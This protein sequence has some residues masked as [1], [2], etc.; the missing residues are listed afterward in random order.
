MESGLG[1]FSWTS[2]DGTKVCRWQH[3]SP[4]GVSCRRALV[5]CRGVKFISRPVP[6]FPL[7]LK[8][9]QTH[10]TYKEKIEKYILDIE[11]HKRG[12]VAW[13][14]HSRTS[15]SFFSSLF[16]LIPRITPTRSIEEYKSFREW[17]NTYGRPEECS[18]FFNDERPNVSAVF[19]VYGDSG[20]FF[21]NLKIIRTSRQP[22]QLFTRNLD[23]EPRIF[24]SA[25]ESELVKPRARALREKHLEKSSLEAP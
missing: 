23:V 2:A 18:F 24:W 8:N 15:Q 3:R 6:L 20:E 12:Y 5:V 25:H 21:F 1:N 13:R 16:N 9:S 17:K 14:V 4:V 7:G 19:N 10:T 11:I 22:L